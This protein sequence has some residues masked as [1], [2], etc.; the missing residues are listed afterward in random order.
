MPSN[1]EIVRAAYAAAER[2]LDVEG[3]INLFA[4]DG[5]LYDVS[6]GK[7]YH[8][9]EVGDLVT[10]FDASFP[11]LRRKLDKFYVDG[12]VVVVEL[13]LNGTHTGPLETPNG[14]VPASGKKIEAPCCDVW[15]LKDTKIQS[16]HCY[17][18]ATILAA[19][20]K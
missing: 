8:G 16:F 19:Q 11:D 13:S 1:E 17:M 10:G 12:N 14:T 15:T 6:A 2:P 20:I 9:R 3:F 18:A 4:E 7:K 5:Y